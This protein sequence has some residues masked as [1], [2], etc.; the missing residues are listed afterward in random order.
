MATTGDDLIRGTIDNDTLAGLAGNDT[1]YGFA[2]NDLVAGDNTAR[3]RG[4]DELYSGLGDDTVYGGAGN[5]VIYN[6]GG[7]DFLYGGSGDDLLFLGDVVYGSAGYASG[8]DGNDTFVVTTTQTAWVYGGAGYD[9]LVLVWATLPDNDAVSVDFPA[10]SAVSTGGQI[11]TYLHLEQL[12]LLS[13]GGNDTITG[14]NY[15]DVI[16]VSTGNNQVYGGS[17]DD[18]ISYKIW[19]ANTLI[20]GVGDDLLVVD[21]GSSPL[22]FIV[23]GSNGRV[24]DGNLSLITNFEFYD[25]YGGAQND[26]ASLGTRADF[27][28]GWLGADTA[29]GAGGDDLLYGGRQEDDL[30]GGTGNDRLFGGRENDRLYGGDGRDVLKGEQGNDLL[31]GG[32]GPDVFLF[33]LGDS[34]LDTIADFTSGEDQIRY[35]SGKLG[36]LSPG[37][38]PLDPSE[39][40]IG[41]SLTTP[42]VFVLS[43]DV[44]TDISQLLWS[45]NGFG[46][47]L[48]MQFEG[49]V[50]LVASDIILF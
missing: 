10:S 44:G 48:L 26:I 15:A 16:D 11:L 40:Q 47:F 49:N 6:E 46:A 12:F 9:T 39:L 41:G 45:D 28:D 43:Y 29:F 27:F 32:L 24:D 18:E 22:Y 14:G 33:G 35:A 21:T 3:D 30:Y 31:T 7:N 50:S 4:N 5:D 17:G 1:I 38:G 25:V 42:G 2:G 37:P 8:E 23:D 19:G 36:V 20:G 13:G 34:G